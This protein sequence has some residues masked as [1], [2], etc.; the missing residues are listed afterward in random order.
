MC[1]KQRRLSAYYASR[2]KGVSCAFEK[3][4]GKS[5]CSGTARTESDSCLCI[6]LQ[7]EM[8]RGHWNP[9]IIFLYLVMDLCIHLNYV[10]LLFD[11][12]LLSKMAKLQC[13]WENQWIRL[14]TTSPRPL[15]MVQSMIFPLWQ[16]TLR[17]PQMLHWYQ[18]LAEDK[19]ASHNHAYDFT[20]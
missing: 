4:H 8:Y 1:L 9:L 14:Q 17:T 20:C 19:E 6:S 7:M 12:V 13:C 10:K 2:S 3:E 11:R 18:Y 16:W 5:T 15:G